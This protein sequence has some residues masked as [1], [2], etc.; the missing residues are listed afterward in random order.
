M[1]PQT[2]VHQSNNEFGSPVVLNGSRHH[3]IFSRFSCWQGKVPAGQYANFLG[4]KTKAEFDS[5]SPDCPEIHYCKPDYPVHDE[6][7]FEWIDLLQAVITA[8][9]HFTMIE[10]GAGFGRWICNA[11]AALKQVN[12]LP[13][14]LIGMEA[15]PTH[16]GWMKEHLQ[17]NGVDPNCCQL[18]QAAVAAQDGEIGFEVGQ[19]PVYGGPKDYYGQ[20]IGGKTLVKAISL[21]TLLQPLKKVDPH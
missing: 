4:I 18:I 16:F 5:L 19:H 9:E 3:P 8:E 2:A 10:L 15:E 13:C 20:A 21:N 11:A 7:Y 6:Q 17:V 12:D 14:T 1:D